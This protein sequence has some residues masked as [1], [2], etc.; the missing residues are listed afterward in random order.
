MFELALA[1]AL[2]LLLVGAAALLFWVPWGWL[3][4]AGIT[5]AA[6]GLLVGVPT[7]LVYHVRLRAV[8]A[9]AGALPARWWLHPT[10]LHERIDQARRRYVMWPFHAGAAGFLAII[11]GCG[12]AVV[13]LL[14]S[15]WG[16]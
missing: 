6:L 11:I 16:Q 7:G 2:A 15:P 3:L 8:L 5:L 12:L 9:H 13:G 1:G 10:R 4:A 14:R